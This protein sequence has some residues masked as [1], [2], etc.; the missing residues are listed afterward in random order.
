MPTSGQTEEFSREG[1]YAPGMVVGGDY[2]LTHFLGKGGMGAVFVAEHRL[3]PD[4]PVALKILFPHL[5]NQDTWLRFQREARVLGKLDHRGI[6]KILNMGVDRERCPFYVMELLSGYAL[7]DFVKKQGRVSLDV[8]LPLFLQVA[9]ALEFAHRNAVIHRDLKPSNIM[10]VDNESRS[11]ASRFQSKVVDFGIATQVAERGSTLF[12][13]VQSLTRT[14]EIFGTPY[15]MSPE[16]IMGQELSPSTDVYSLGC[17]L[18]EVLTGK[19]PFRG[20]TAFDTISMHLKAS[21]PRLGG[22][23]GVPFA[24]E[25]ELVIARA[26]AKDPA[27]RYASM[28]LFS[29]DLNRAYHGYSV[30]GAGI[31]S[32]GFD[33]AEREASAE[34]H[35]MMEAQSS[36]RS[37]QSALKTLILT[38]CGL[39]LALGIGFGITAIVTGIQDSTRTKVKQLE[40]NELSAGRVSL[41]AI[42]QD[43]GKMDGGKRS[44]LLDDV[45]KDD[46]DALKAVLKDAGLFNRPPQGEF[47]CFQFPPHL[48]AGEFNLSNG[49]S[50]PA[51]GFARVPI[52]SHFIF[53]LRQELS[54][55]VI[56][57]FKTD[58][59]GIH[60]EVGRLEDL[61]ELVRVMRGW[62]RLDQLK[63]KGCP[64]SKEVMD[65]LDKLPPIY[66]LR[67]YNA[68]VPRLDF[69]KAKFLQRTQFIEVDKMRETDDALRAG[70]DNPSSPNYRERS[71]IFAFMQAVAKMPKLVSLGGSASP[72]NDHI[73]DELSK[74]KTLKR[75]NYDRTYISPANL[76]K[77]CAMPGVLEVRTTDTI[78]T[79]EELEK[80]VPSAKRSLHL[81]IS[82]PKLTPAQK[83]ALKAL[84]RN[85]SVYD[86]L[87]TRAEVNRMAKRVALFE[88]V[89]PV[90]YYDPDKHTY[91]KFDNLE[92]K[93][94]ML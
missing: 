80:A 72:M 81:I 92:G 8:A 53:S 23:A 20:A 91:S 74:S 3:M 25:I 62:K 77:L 94:G 45:M 36:R 39:G 51:K 1:E 6:V 24:E 38:M 30:V 15:Y 64:L 2:K 68:E 34:E 22:T 4:N 11:G 19:P 69:S 86:G 28:L 43:I 16:Q 47:T 40:Q 65:E 44:G 55:V 88:M 63:L 31:K 35:F 49:F 46:D 13:E 12:R 50:V 71:G 78:Y 61:K 33:R 93:F 17:T 27:K 32:S 76:R 85:F 18:F 60:V 58:S 56:E 57:H 29:N 75:I 73:A 54:P 26:L 14:G 89:P 70:M 7:S 83:S 67:L 41:L 82:S 87:W 21:P 52:H 79:P 5:V 90:N 48:V 84:G 37:R 66:S 9:D 59:V 42:D 10:L